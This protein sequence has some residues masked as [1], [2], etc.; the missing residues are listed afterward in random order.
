MEAAI[1]AELNI[2]T[3]DLDLSM[4]VDHGH[5]GE[6]VTLADKICK[7]A[8]SKLAKGSEW[9][10]IR[11]RVEQIKTEEIR[12][13]VGD[14]I[15]ETV[16]A[17]VRRTNTFGEPLGEPKTLREVI[18]EEAKRLINEPADRYNPD[19]GTVLGKLVRDEVS[20]AIRVELAEA[21]AAEKAKVVAAIRAQAADLIAQAVSQGIGG[22]K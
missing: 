21:L 9:N 19:R 12:R 14:L 20:R 2:T 6:P 8:V 17:D 4:V 1:K 10:G 5:E 15:T 22:V 7:S 3:P 16:S 11:N 18:V 13:Y